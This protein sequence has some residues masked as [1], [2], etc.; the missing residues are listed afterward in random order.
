VATGLRGCAVIICKTQ[1][2]VRGKVYEAS[3]VNF[4]LRALRAA[5]FPKMAIQRRRSERLQLLF[6]EI[7]HH[8]QL[9]CGA[10]QLRITK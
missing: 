8:K 7:L 2:I 1:V 6:E 4:Y 5:D 10:N 3:A 9:N